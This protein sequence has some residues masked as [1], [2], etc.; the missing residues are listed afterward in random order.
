MLSR[1]DRQAEILGWIGGILCL[2]AYLMVSFK[3]LDGASACYQV[4]NLTSSIILIIYLWIRRAY[5]SMALNFA[6]A[7]IAIIALIKGLPLIL[8]GAF[9]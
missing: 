5:S 6:W 8:K 4:M 1:K 2:T 7:T 9:F 3:I